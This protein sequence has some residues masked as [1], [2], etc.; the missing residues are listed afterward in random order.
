ML[1][2]ES[3]RQTE[4]ARLAERGAGADADDVVEDASADGIDQDLVPRDVPLPPHAANDNAETIV[5]E[6]TTSFFVI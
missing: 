2:E 3:A 1:P 6:T 4:P 5:A